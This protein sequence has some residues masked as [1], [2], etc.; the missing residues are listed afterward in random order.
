MR[1]AFFGFQRWGTETLGALLANG[2]DAPLVVTHPPSRN[3]ADNPCAASVDALARGSAQFTPQDRSQA[4]FFHQRGEREMRIDGS[5]PACDIHNL[6]R[7]RATRAH[8]RQPVLRRLLRLF[9]RVP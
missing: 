5:L 7:A 6:I 1:I 2:H 9:R 8:A 3:P 4:P